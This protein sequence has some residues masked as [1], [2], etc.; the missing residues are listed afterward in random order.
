MVELPRLLLRR[1]ADRALANWRATSGPGMTI[2]IVLGNDLAMH[3][4]AGLADIEHAVPIGPATTFRIASVTKQFTCAAI[5]LLASEGKLSPDDDVRDHLPRFPD[6]GHR[7]TLDHLMHNTSGIRD[8]LEIMRLGGIDLGHPVEPQDLLDG[9]NRQRGLNFEPGSRY[10]YSNSNFMLLG[11][12]VERVSGEPFRDFLDRRIFAP[13]GMNA[14]RHVERTTEIV[15]NLATGYLPA[16]DGWLRAQ[17]G[18]PL[19]GEGGL[20]S[21]VTDLA[22]W[23]A[24]IASPR[25]GGT[26][27]ANALTEMTPFTNGKPNTYARGLRIKTH[28]GVRM[29]GHD[30][31]WPGYKTSFVRIPDH[32]AA[33]ICISN[34]GGS[35][36]H[37]LAFQ[38]VDALIEDKPGIHPVPPMPATLPSAGRYLNRDTGATVELA[39]DKA[40]RRTATTHGVTFPLIPTEDGCL[41]TSRGSN[42]FTLRLLPDDALE[43]ERDAGMRENLHRLTTDATLPRD[44]PGRYFN[45]D[46]AA[47]WTIAPGTTSMIAHIAGPMRIAVT[48]EIEPVEGDCIR[49]ITPSNLFRAWLDVRILRDSN[50]AITGLHVDGSRARNL[51]FA[52]I[53]E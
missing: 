39:I 53:R 7:I 38:M 18:F 46:V 20:V 45:A 40:G 8:M 34:D 13:L 16:R 52:R 14:T 17:H 44:L 5:L 31:L 32:G 3:E 33:V 15:P 23:H 9:L 51:V 12:I 42:D 1:R 41:T 27:L 19:H 43:L 6:L 24:N 48:W 36:P 47:T 37:D 10:L 11:R 22:L 49:I 2:G 4:S 30:G 35:D 50:G 26:A 28:R 21:C 29:I 25:I